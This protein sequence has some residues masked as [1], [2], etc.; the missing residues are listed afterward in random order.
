[1]GRSFCGWLDVGAPSIYEFAPYAAY[2]ATVRLF[3]Q[4]AVTFD[5]ISGERPGNVADIAYL[6]PAPHQ[7]WM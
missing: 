2:V 5:L 3:F 6:L 1:M 7:L 4:L